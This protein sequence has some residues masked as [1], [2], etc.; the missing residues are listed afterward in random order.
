MRPLGFFLIISNSAVPM[1][2]WT[3]SRGER[4]T[5]DFLDGCAFIGKSGCDHGIPLVIVGCE[6]PA[7]VLMSLSGTLN[8]M[9]LSEPVQQDDR[10]I[11]KTAANAYSRGDR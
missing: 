9:I 10:L 2:D 8:I 11:K 4:Q 1:D 7:A 5:K 3:N 6:S